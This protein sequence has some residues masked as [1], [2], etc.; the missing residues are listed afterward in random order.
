MLIKKRIEEELLAQESEN[1]AST[2]EA[3]LSV[4]YALSRNES[5]DRSGYEHELGVSKEF[6]LNGVQALD[7]KSLQL[8][9]EANLIESSIDIVS[10]ENYMKNLYHQHCL[11]D[12]YLENLRE[13]YA[14]FSELYEKKKV[15]FAQGEIATNR[16]L[17]QLELEK[18]RLGISLQN[19]E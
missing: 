10:V 7:R 1:L 17:L 15:A 3:P 5:T 11:D 13:A 14:K 8:E 6:F 2:E 9:S 4:N 16:S 19:R 18:S 12:E